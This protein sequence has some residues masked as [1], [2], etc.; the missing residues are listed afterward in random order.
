MLDFKNKKVAV[1]GLAKTG[2]ALIKFLLAKGAK[3]TALDKK[4]KEE[5][6]DVYK[7]LEGLLVDFRLGQKYL[8][9]LEKFDFIFI[10]P[11]VPA[12]LPQLEE[13]RKR[14]QRISSETELFF[15][16]CP[17]KIIGITGTNGKTTTVTLIA[18]LLKSETRDP[19]AKTNS[20]S[21]VPI[22][23]FEVWVGG[24]IG[25]PLIEMVEQIKPDDLVV[26]ELSSFQ[27]ENLK[28]SPQIAVILNITPDH[29]DRHKTFENYIAAKTN[30]IKYQNSTDVAIL[31]FDDPVTSKLAGKT[32]AR[33]VLFS[34]NSKLDEGVF[35]KNKKIVSSIKG[36][37]EA[38]LGLED[39]KIPGEH[40]ISNVLAALAVA[41]VVGVSR[42]TIKS[43]VSNFAGVEHRIEFTRELDGIRY[44]NDSKATTP[45]STIAALEAFSSPIILIAGGYDK[46]A[47]FTKLAEK[48][49]EKVKYLVLLGQTKDQIAGAVKIALEEVGGKFREFR[50]NFAESLP[51]AIRLARAKGEKG[52]IVLLSPA[53]ASWDMFKSFEERGRLFKEIVNG[54]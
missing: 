12:D 18:E 16:L 52:D 43:V 17:G 30:I 5:L 47:D 25:E 49:V 35:L 34:L 31:N 54:F 22:P 10:S 19:K 11:G 24:N 46:H 13:A 8:E 29:L 9:G 1:V 20:Q 32:A 48:I 3:I 7:E 21:K 42:E 40:N 33:L 14:G 39:I 53:C 6:G 51:E 2:T 36:K 28:K 38:L 44:Y 15:D 23:K 37:E 27:L 45:D 4:I 41:D 50:H 26:L